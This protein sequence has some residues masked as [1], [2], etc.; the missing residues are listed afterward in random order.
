[1]M[2]GAVRGAIPGFVETTSSALS[3]T[4]TVKDSVRSSS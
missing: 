1:M 4:V 3:L 2:A